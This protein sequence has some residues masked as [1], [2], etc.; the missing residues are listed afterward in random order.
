MHLSIGCRYVSLAYL[1]LVVAVSP[2]CGAELLAGIAKAD[3]TP[4]P[5]LL[6]WGYS[7]RTDPATGALDPL[8]ARALVLRA[9][10]TTV[11]LVTLDL[12]R[13][14][15]D[16]L[17]DGLRRRAAE[18]L[19]IDEIFVTASHT[20]AAPSL[21]SW[22]G[23]PNAFGEKVVETIERL[24]NEALGRLAPVRLGITHVDVDLAHNRRRVLADRRVAM[25]WR[26]AEREPTRPI[27]RQAT[28]VRLEGS[29]RSTVAVLVHFACHPVV[30]GADNLQYS[31]DF[32]GAACSLVESTLDTT[33]FYLQGACGDLNPYVD[34]TPLASG[35][36][37][38]M[39]AAGRVLGTAVGDAARDAFMPESAEG[40][41]LA[42]RDTVPVRVRW[43]VNDPA[44]A[45]VLSRV[46]GPR[47][48]RYLQERLRQGSIEIPLTTLVVNDRLALVGMPGEVFVRFQLALKEEAPY[49]ETL[50]VGYTNGYHAYFPTIRD[51][52]LGSYGGKVATYVEVGAGDRL[53]DQALITLYRLQGRLPAVPAPS[54]FQMLEWDDVKHR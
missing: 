42:V 43:D 8:T 31:A 7:N 39:Q 40:S 46:Y 33:M 49:P 50:L 36:I 10:E 37:A 1:A 28:V 22:E 35:G 24:L 3:I 44:V 21:E 34:K 2:T 45:G 48:D 54:D 52:A 27:D 30:L 25:Q 23:A 19:D 26:N 20:H 13:T 5:G 14:P 11:A 12:G 38:A 51:A 32:V 17:L 18:K 53:T 16:V 47:F 9:G 41:V 29:D 4:P 6:M 15:E